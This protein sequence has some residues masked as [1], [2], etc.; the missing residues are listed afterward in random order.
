MTSWMVTKASKSLPLP[1]QK[2]DSQVSPREHSLHRWPQRGEWLATYEKV[3]KQKA[4]LWS[5]TVSTDRRRR[6][7]GHSWLTLNKSG[8]HMLPPSLGLSACPQALGPGL[9]LHI[10]LTPALLT[11]FPPYCYIL[12]FSD[13]QGC[14]PK[15]K[16]PHSDSGKIL[17]R[18]AWE[19]WDYHPLL[20]ELWDGSNC[21]MPC[22]WVWRG[23]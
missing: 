14:P 9:V 8:F 22:S 2:P 17:S 21:V 16:Q 12:K 10:D 3:K 18:W 7:G 20:P 6:A 1:P 15:A 13:I 11:P 23:V 5:M 19:H 4:P